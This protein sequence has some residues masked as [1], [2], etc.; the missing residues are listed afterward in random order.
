M[1]LPPK[2][3]GWNTT[4][5]QFAPKGVRFSAGLLTALGFLLGFYAIFYVFCLMFAIPRH[6]HTPI[7]LGGKL[8][9]SVAGTA[10]LALICFQ[11]AVAMRQARKWAA[12][13]AIALGLL[14]LA[15]GGQILL[16]LFWPYRPG[17][18]QGEDMFGILAAVPCIV[19]GL[20]WCVYLTLPHVRRQFK[21]AGDRQL[22][23]N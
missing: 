8:L 20:W 18:V 22:S 12:Y 9:A 4:A 17:D 21:A 6:Y 2:I 7:T 19:I 11:T 16:D 14:L 13:A 15:F 10:I 3:R 23:K 5:G 1:T